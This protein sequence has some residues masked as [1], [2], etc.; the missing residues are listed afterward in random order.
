MSWNHTRGRS[1]MSKAGFCGLSPYGGAS[2]A[3]KW[4][5]VV[6]KE[7]MFEPQSVDDR[8]NFGGASLNNCEQQTVMN[9][10]LA[11]RRGPIRYRRNAMIVCEGDPTDYILLIVKGVIRSCKTYRNGSRGIVAFHFSGELFGWSNDPIH[12]LSAEAAAE[13]LVLFFKRSALLAAALR[14]GRIA[15]YLLATTTNELR[16]VQEHSLLLSRLAECRVATFLMDLSTRMGNTNYL[17]LPMAH[18]D[19]ASHLGLEIETLSRSITALEK[20]G[21]IARVGGRRA[22]F[23]RD[24]ASLERMSD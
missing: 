8:Y 17:D 11:L 1:L 22:L 13:T 9:S 4:T 5:S 7:Q 18:Y 19:I 12:S 10:I 16:R 6:P 21:S 24:R 2:F 15:T 14:D 20:S 3:K 23:L